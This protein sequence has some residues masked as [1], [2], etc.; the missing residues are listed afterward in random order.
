MTTGTS[1]PGFERDIKPLF[2]E[3]DKDA[4]DFVFDLWDYND[5]RTHAE[6]ILERLEDGTMP[7]DGE[8][9][10]EQVELFRRWIEAGTPA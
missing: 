9:P 1:A 6:S 2:R 10:P 7:C 8:W 3:D 5:V 4:M